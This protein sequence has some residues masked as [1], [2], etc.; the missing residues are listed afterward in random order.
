MPA[1]TGVPDGV[2][3]TVPQP[4]GARTPAE[5]VTLMRKLQLWSGLSTAELEAR[6]R[7]PGGVLVP[8][9]LPALLSGDLLPREETL[10]AFLVACGCVP[11]VRARWL[12]A[13]AR[14]AAVRSAPPPADGEADDVRVAGRPFKAPRAGTNTRPML[15][16]APIAQPL[17]TGPQPVQEQLQPER[18]YPPSAHEHTQHAQDFQRPGQDL[19]RHVR[20]FPLP[21]L[22]PPQSTQPAQATQPARA[23]QTVQ[24]PQVAQAT[25]HVQAVQPPPPVQGTQPPQ[26]APDGEEDDRRGAAGGRRRGRSEGARRSGGERRLGREPRAAGR[27][28][29]TGELPVVDAIPEPA[30]A[31]EAAPGRAGRHRATGDFPVVAGRRR[32]HISPQA[33]TVSLITAAAVVFA[34]VNTVKDG[35]REAGQAART[36]RTTAA[37]PP[38]DGRYSLSPVTGEPNVNCLA[39]MNDDAARPTLSQHV[40]DLD[41][42]TEKFWLESQR[43]GGHVLKG[44]ASEDE[45]KP[46]CVTLDSGRDGARL[47]LMPCVPGEP[48]QQFTFRPIGPPPVNGTAIF[49]MLPVSTHA[50]GMCVGVDPVRPGTV[51]AVHTSCFRAGVQGFTFTPARGA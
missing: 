35:G 23:V 38:K 32:G 33:A 3:R 8:G 13:H 31:P 36:E 11:E 17:Q 44:R 28:R 47:H 6:L 14:L 49:Q 41:D 19:T 18:E 46:R 25:Q 26:L 20:E 34:L 22:K 10:A 21:T 7:D 42:T 40:C 51:H 16:G 27:H 29:S 1:K 12:E 37:L 45:A 50:N 2:R 39:I 15:A 30:Q 24:G 43:K 4:E 5:F 9:G 48:R